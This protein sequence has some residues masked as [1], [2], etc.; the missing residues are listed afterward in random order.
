MKTYLITDDSGSGEFFA[1]DW[2]DA[3]EQAEEWTQE[4]YEDVEETRWVDVVI[5]DTE[6]GEE[7]TRDY[8]FDPKPPEC[9]EDEHDW[10]APHSIL[11]GLEENPGVWGHGGGTI[12]TDIC[13][14]CGCA[15]TVDTW[16][17]NPSNGSQGH[18]SVKYDADYLETK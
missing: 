17:T 7:R 9:T 10:Y 4:L 11:G 1:N 15:R 2:E 18:E 8:T 5:T 16:A 6:T 14:H 13:K 3:L 12:S